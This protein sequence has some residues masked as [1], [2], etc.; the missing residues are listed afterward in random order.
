MLS[1]CDALGRQLRSESLNILTG[2][3]H[4]EVNIND[5]PVGLYFVRLESANK[6]YNKKIIKN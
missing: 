2:K 1:V 5:L 3:N 4:H 6:V